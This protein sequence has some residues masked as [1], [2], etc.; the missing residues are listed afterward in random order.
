MYK[1]FGDYP[2]TELNYETP[3]QLLLAVMLSAQTTDKQ[4]NKVTAEFFRAVKT[5]GDVLRLWEKGIKEYIKTVWLHVAKTKNIVK[6]AQQMNDLRE[7]YM[8]DKKTM[9]A[10]AAKPKRRDATAGKRWYTAWHDVYADRGYIIPDTIEDITHL[11]GVGIKTAKV[12]LYI[13]YGKKLIAV[14]THVYRVMSRLGIVSVSTPEKASHLLETIIPDNYKDMAHQVII[15]FGRYLCKAQKPECFRC[16][17]T[18][19]CLWYKENVLNKK[20]NI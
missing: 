6:L 18:D 15:Y 1:L 10:W 2:T 12:V 4:V 17:L 3:F 20:K 7:T 14:D 11:A 8:Q 16:P 13:L 9:R 5:P 19:M